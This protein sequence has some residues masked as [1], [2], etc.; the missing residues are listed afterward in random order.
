MKKKK[1]E[2]E[3]N[4]YMIEKCNIQKYNKIQKEK[5][6][7]FNITVESSKNKG[8]D[9]LY[10]VSILIEELYTNRSRIDV[11]LC[12]FFEFSNDWEDDDRD[13]F[14]NVSAPAIL[15]PYIR[16]FISNVTAFDVDET[17]V[18]P[19]INFADLSIRKKD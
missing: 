4:G 12:G 16:T 19:I 10:R 14:L 13:Y 18:L 2:V 7:T 3:F 17:V 11:E 9:K 1:N 8:N 5:E 6:K 15:Y